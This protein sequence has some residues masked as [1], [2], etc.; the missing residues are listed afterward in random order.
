MGTE[1][2]GETELDEAKKMLLYSDFEHYQDNCEFHRNLKYEYDLLMKSDDEFAL[3]VYQALCNM[4]WRKKGF[5]NYW[6][7]VFMK[8]H[9]GV[10]YSCS[11]RYAGGLVAEI[12]GLGESYIDFYCSGNEGIVT[13]RIKKN[14]SMMRSG[15]VPFP[16]NHW[17]EKLRRFINKKDRRY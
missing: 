4:R 2:Q 7:C 14:F 13:K 1:N 5:M 11:W 10:L 15:W 9:S 17:S 3:E 16:W 8:R 6:K 12:R